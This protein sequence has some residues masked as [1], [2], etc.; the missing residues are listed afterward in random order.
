MRVLFSFLVL[1][2]I[3]TLAMGVVWGNFAEA[4]GGDAGARAIAFLAVPV[5]LISFTLLSR[6]VSKVSAGHRAGKGG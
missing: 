3:A 2:F 6:I 5:A 4:R 1:L